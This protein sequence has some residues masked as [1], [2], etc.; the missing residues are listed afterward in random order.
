MGDTSLERQILQVQLERFGGWLYGIELGAGVRTPG[1][2][3]VMKHA[4]ARK[5]AIWPVLERTFAGRWSDV[6]C[7]DVACA[8]GFFSSHLARFRPRT[9]TSLDALSENVDKTK[10]VLSCQKATGVRVDVCDIYGLSTEKT[11]SFD[12][13]LCL[14]LVSYVEDP[15]FVLRRLRALTRELCIFD[16]RVAARESITLGAATDVESFLSVRREPGTHWNPSA[17]KSG[18]A[19]VPSERAIE[20]MVL[21]AGFRRIEKLADVPG[22]GTDASLVVLAWV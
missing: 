13:S 5:Q 8:E 17:S 18:V 4:E 1:S 10:F 21:Q 16:T 6:T 2:T 20:T 19:L 15:M 11:G 9:L 3:L 12:L 14:G 7:I 22:T